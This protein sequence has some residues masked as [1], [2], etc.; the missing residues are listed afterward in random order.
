[1]V[2]SPQTA[3]TPTMFCVSQVAPESPKLNAVQVIVERL[4]AQNIPEQHRLQPVL[5]SPAPSVFP[6]WQG[7]CFSMNSCTDMPQQCVLQGNVQRT[8]EAP[9]VNTDQA[10]ATPG[11]K[12]TTAEPAN[13]G[14]IFTAQ[15][16][17][18]DGRSSSCIACG[19]AKHELKTLACQVAGSCLDFCWCSLCSKRAPDHY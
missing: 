4:E 9:A 6:H 11:R 19:E 17:G 8:P 12:K 3:N 18:T 13:N 15:G 1:M 10:G 14:H 16:N 5:P 2:G 7:A